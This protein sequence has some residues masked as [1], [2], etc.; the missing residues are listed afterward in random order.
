MRKNFRSN[1]LRCLLRGA[2][3]FGEG[4]KNRKRFLTERVHRSKVQIS[5]FYGR[6]ISAPTPTFT[7]YSRRGGNLPPAPNPLS[8]AYARQLSQRESLFIRS[9][10]L[11][12]RWHGSAVTERVRCRIFVSLINSL[13]KNINHKV[14]VCRECNPQ[15]IWNLKIRRGFVDFFKAQNHKDNYKP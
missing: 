7:H 14:K 12:G 5:V 8:L 6:I 9:L 13:I 2:S 10:P 1:F 11:W 3:H 4:G 15:K